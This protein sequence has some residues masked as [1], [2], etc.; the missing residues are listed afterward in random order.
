MFESNLDRRERPSS[1]KDAFTRRVLNSPGFVCAFSKYV[2]KYVNT[3]VEI[4]Y[5]KRE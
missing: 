1:L 4:I 3:K 5:R 2:H